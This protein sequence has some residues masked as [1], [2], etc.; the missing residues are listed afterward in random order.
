MLVAF[1][2]GRI[3]TGAF[4]IYHASHNFLSIRNVISRVAFKGIP[5]PGLAVVIS[6][7]LLIVAGLSFITGFLPTIGVCAAVLFLVPVTFIMHNFW[8]LPE[9]AKQIQMIMFMKNISMMG[10]MLLIIAFGSGPKSLKAN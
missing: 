3:L 1:M 9:A 6:E 10:G 2:V 4:Y 5:F 8:A 7:I